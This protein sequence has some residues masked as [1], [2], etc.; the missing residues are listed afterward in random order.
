MYL[1]TCIEESFFLKEA[2]YYKSFGIQVSV[3]IN[4]T[5]VKKWCISDISLDRDFVLTLAQQCTDGQLHP[6]HL[7]DVVNDALC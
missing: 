5:E 7:V 1:Y 2:G 6:C 3:V 4:H